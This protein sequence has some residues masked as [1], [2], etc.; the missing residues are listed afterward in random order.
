F[1][2]VPDSCILAGEAWSEKQRSVTPLLTKKLRATRAVACERALFLTSVPRFSHLLKPSMHL[3]PKC[4]EALAFPGFWKD[5]PV[6]SLKKFLDF[7]FSEGDLKDE[8]TEHYLYGGE[9]KTLSK[10]YAEASEMGTKILQWKKDSKAVRSFWK[11][12]AKTENIIVI[13]KLREEKVKRR[14]SAAETE[15]IAKVREL[16]AAQHVTIASVATEQ[17]Q[18][19]ALST[20]A[21]NAKRFSNREERTAKRNQ[22]DYEVDFAKSSE[23]EEDEL[24]SSFASRA[25]NPEENRVLS[26]INPRLAKIGGIAHYQIIFLPERGLH[27]EIKEKFNDQEWD[28]LILS[29]AE[30]EEKITQQLPSTVDGNVKSLLDKY[31]QA[32][33]DATTGFHVE[34]SPVVKAISES[35]LQGHATMTRPYLFTRDWPVQWVQQVYT[36]FLTCYQTPNNLLHDASASE[37]EY[38]DLIVNPIWRNLFFDVSHIIRMRTGEIENSDRKLQKNLSKFPYERRAIGWLHDGI[39]MMKIGSVDMQVAFG[40]VVGNACDQ[41]DGK[42]CEDRTKIMKAMQ[43]A[44]VK[45]RRFLLEKGVDKGLLWELETYGILIDKKDFCFYSMHQVDGYFLVN[46]FDNFTIPDNCGHLGELPH[47]IQAMLSFKS[48]VLHLHQRV[49]SLLKNRQG[50]SAPRVTEDFVVPSPRKRH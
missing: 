48:R 13:S 32:V 46:Q 22:S 36:A 14:V 49:E 37:Y 30:A 42:M 9:L 18:E 29:W 10:F 31:D 20:T 41:N 50:Q 25:S 33:A 19:Y 6:P 1:F 23:D 40:E 24:D 11:I 15:A 27:D 8:A 21:R 47:I 12:Q 5:V 45:L 44:L 43:L 39:L 7:R 3:L 4:L 2:E 35:P 16:Q 28:A 26:S 34:F 38:R 17:V